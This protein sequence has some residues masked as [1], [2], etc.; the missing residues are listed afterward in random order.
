MESPMEKALFS[1][2]KSSTQS[3]KKLSLKESKATS[4]NMDGA[5]QNAK[6]L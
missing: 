3:V 5:T 4:K 1:L 6:I 2:I